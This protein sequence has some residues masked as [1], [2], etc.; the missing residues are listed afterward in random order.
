MLKQCLLIAYTMYCVFTVFCHLSCPIRS[1]CDTGC[2]VLFQG[3]YDHNHIYTHQDIGEIIEEARFRGIRV[4][5]EFDT[6]GRS[7]L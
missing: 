1:L 5:P 6:P 7:S 2:F 4:I 3:A